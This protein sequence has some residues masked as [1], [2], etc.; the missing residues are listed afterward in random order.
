MV[1]RFPCLSFALI[2][3]IG[4]LLSKWSQGNLLATLH[5]VLGDDGDGQNHGKKART[6]VAYFADPD[7][8]IATKLIETG[9][10]KDSTSK[11]KFMSVADYIQYRSGGSGSNREGVQFTAQERG[12]LQGITSGHKLATGSSNATHKTSGRQKKKSDEL[13]PPEPEPP[14]VVFGRLESHTGSLCAQALVH[15]QGV[16]ARFLLQVMLLGHPMSSLLQS[17]CRV[18]YQ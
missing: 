1:S 7:P 8:D 5:R 6:S 4:S 12:R 9:K 18:L 16:P 11:T 13:K 14:E 17:R 15:T 10:E 3:N 2:V